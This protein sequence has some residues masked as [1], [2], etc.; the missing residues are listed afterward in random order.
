MQ[1]SRHV[2]IKAKGETNLSTLKCSRIFCR[3]NQIFLDSRIRLKFHFRTSTLAPPPSAHAGQH[4]CTY[5]FRVHLQVILS[6]RNNYWSRSTLFFFLVSLFYSLIPKI[7]PYYSRNLYFLLSKLVRQE[8]Q[9][10]A[11]TV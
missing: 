7:I 10:L 6:P 11:G 2:H 3:F 1:V 4:P 8:I 9:K 5:S